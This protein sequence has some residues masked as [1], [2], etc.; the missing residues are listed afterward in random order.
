MGGLD[1]SHIPGTESQN[2]FDA[3]QV[4]G[5]AFCQRIDLSNHSGSLLQVHPG[6]S[7]KRYCHRRGPLYRTWDIFAIEQAL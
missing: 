5:M 3:H 4:G 6:E 2:G 7:L 1:W